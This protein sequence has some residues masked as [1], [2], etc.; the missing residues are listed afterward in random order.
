MADID[1]QLLSIRRW[2]ADVQAKRSTGTAKTKKIVHPAWHY[3]SAQEGKALQGKWLQ[4]KA[5][6]IRQ[7][8]GQMLQEVAEKLRRAPETPEPLDWR[9]YQQQVNE[10]LA[11][12]EQQRDDRRA[13][14]GVGKMRN[15]QAF[16]PPA[17]KGDARPVIT[18][19][20]PGLASSAAQEL[21]WQ[22]LLQLPGTAKL[23]GGIT[24]ASAARVISYGPLQRQEE[25]ID[26]QGR[27]V[28]QE[29]ERSG[30]P[31]LQS[32]QGIG[33][34]KKQSEEKLVGW[35][36]DGEPLY[37]AISAPVDEIKLTD[38]FVKRGKLNRQWQPTL[39]NDPTALKKN[40]PQ[41]RVET[42]NPGTAGK[43]RRVG[44]PLRRQAGVL[45]R[46]ELAPA[47]QVIEGEYRQQ[48]AS[49][50]P[51]QM[52]S[53]ESPSG[54]EL[55]EVA[56]VSGRAQQRALKLLDERVQALQAA[57]LDVQFKPQKER[58]EDFEV[59]PATND[60]GGT[61]LGPYS[62][63][64]PEM[65]PYGSIEVP[66]TNK[67][68]VL[69]KPKIGPQGQVIPE[70]GVNQTIWPAE[71]GYST[72]KD[73]DATAV[74]D[75]QEESSIGKLVGRANEAAKTPVIT[76]KGLELAERSGRFRLPTDAEMAAFA[77]K[78]GGRNNLHGFLLP[79]GESVKPQG[80][81]RWLP[82]Y[83]TNIPAEFDSPLN[84]N[85][86]ERLR[87]GDQNITDAV[88]SAKT[89]LYRVGSP[90]NRI[91]DVLRRQLVGY[92][93]TDPEM[94][95]DMSTGRVDEE[96]L[97]RRS[98]YAAIP[99]V[100]VRTKPYMQKVNKVARGLD[101]YA[102]LQVIKVQGN[103]REI[104]GASEFKELLNEMQFQSSARDPVTGAVSTPYAIETLTFD[105]NRQY[106][107]PNRTYN[108][109][110][111]AKTVQAADVPMKLYL[112]RPNGTIDRIIPVVDEENG[113][114]LKLAIANPKAETVT[115]PAFLSGDSALRKEAEEL[116]S[117]F[118]SQAKLVNALAKGGFMEGAP[119]GSRES[120]V[121]SMLQLKNKDT[122]ENLQPQEIM[123]AFADAGATEAELKLTAK[124]LVSAG[125][126]SRA[127]DLFADSAPIAR[128]DVGMPVDPLQTPP[129]TEVLGAWRNPDY[130]A[131]F[132]PPPQLLRVEGQ[133]AAQGQWQQ[134]VDAS[135]SWNEELIAGA[136]EEERAMR[137]QRSRE[138]DPV[139]YGYSQFGDGAIGEGKPGESSRVGT[140][141]TPKPLSGQDERDR[142]AAG[143]AMKT[144]LE[145]GFGGFP[146]GTLRG[147][148]DVQT[149]LSRL[150]ERTVQDLRAQARLI[151]DAARREAGA[152]ERVVATGGRPVPVTEAGG[153]DLDILARALRMARGSNVRTIGRLLPQQRTATASRGQVAKWLSRP[154]ERFLESDPTMQ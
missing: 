121:R 146:G 21:Y 79:A 22:P 59:D 6:D 80:R 137:E 39:T 41:E 67:K 124:A 126:N 138:E 73:P 91:D 38:R 112:K 11:Q 102:D 106:V 86:I 49:L 140:V 152:T 115:G 128:Q 10:R 87:A 89:G 78:G 114:R 63:P 103:S 98:S 5:A 95:V 107:R 76:G 52:L 47:K 120:V 68:G 110:P 51:V 20:V 117:D 36:E 150:D 35:L 113:G 55:A 135:P 25:Q 16:V 3:R 122:G 60:R 119:V 136:L 101:E 45:S 53:G 33:A 69:V 104:I 40:T 46:S 108:D 153:G 145:A 8:Q 130:R 132:P 1:T 37:K 13:I 56:E 142:Q 151:A 30:P 123:Q 93:V 133:P 97:R 143:I 88:V 57:S 74:W 118:T 147:A 154:N 44:A 66:R 72:I 71:G 17:R 127:V 141:K 32:E 100:D 58:T 2:L 109:Q 105:S 96:S 92:D 15:A 31:K 18:G 75:F 26:A 134:E 116:S 34:F 54:F 111:L 70:K 81:Q 82:V 77:P 131:A 99:G 19:D 4:K 7:A 50:S 125:G 149:A 12:S 139:G 84:S 85:V 23:F 29:G 48:L 129:G 64:S 27:V 94:A 148:D 43:T 144:L 61:E 24:P 42:I 28:K 14:G 62:T 83:K 9:D 65:S 90:T